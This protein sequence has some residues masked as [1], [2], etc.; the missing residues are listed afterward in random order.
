MVK[1]Q[2]G[3]P[4]WSRLIAGVTT[5]TLAQALA[6]RDKSVFSGTYH[7]AAGGSTSWHTFASRIVEMMPEAERRCREVV[8]ITTTEYP[9][10]AKR[11]DYSVL[12]CD[13]LKKTFGVH[14]PGWEAGLRLVLDKS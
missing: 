10:L 13:K 2:F 5:L 6:A 4:T 1:D 14:L 7:L 11:P 9:T 3:C 8:G 12:D